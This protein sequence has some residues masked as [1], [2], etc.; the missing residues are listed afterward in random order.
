MAPVGFPGE[1]GRLGE[2]RVAERREASMLILGNAHR[3]ETEARAMYKS[4]VTSRPCARTLRTSNAG[5][6]Q[7]RWKI[8]QD[9]CRLERNQNG[10]TRTR[11]TWRTS[12]RIVVKESRN[13]IVLFRVLSDK[14]AW[15]MVFSGKC[16]VTM[17]WG[18]GSPYFVI[19]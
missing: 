9:S 10:M 8:G 18:V 15:E 5:R 6:L 17:E 11:L 13:L 14:E 1:V 3:G 7:D 2:R 19:A 16:A 12:L 4:S